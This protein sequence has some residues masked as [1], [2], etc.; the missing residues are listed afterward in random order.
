MPEGTQE[1]VRNVLF[2]ATVDAIMRILP[3]RVTGH[4]IWVL[5]LK[6]TK[7]RHQ[8]KYQ[9][10]CLSPWTYPSLDFSAPVY[11]SHY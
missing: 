11:P 10:A 7:Y 1:K 8:N 3:L 2:L 5:L 9:Y 6:I 4:G